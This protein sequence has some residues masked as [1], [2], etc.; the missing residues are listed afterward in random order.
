MAR[1]ETHKSRRRVRSISIYLDGA[2]IGT[3]GSIEPRRSNRSALINQN[4]PLSFSRMPW[5]SAAMH[6]EVAHKYSSLDKAATHVRQQFYLL[7]RRQDR[8]AFTSWPF[9]RFYTP[10]PRARMHVCMR[11]VLVS[12][13]RTGVHRCIYIYIYMF[14]FVHL[15]SCMQRGG[16]GGRDASIVSRNLIGSRGATR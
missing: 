14:V 10:E 8:A 2:P 11:L 13:H 6:E 3:R 15:N 5:I 16:R 7:E 12:M 1:G 4:W 9:L